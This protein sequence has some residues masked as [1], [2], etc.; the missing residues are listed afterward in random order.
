M[1]ETR[2]QAISDV[3][4]ELQKVIKKYQKPEVNCHSNLSNDATTRMQKN[5]ACDGLVLGSLLKS[6]A[7]NELWPIPLPPFEGLRLVDII[8][9]MRSL[10]P[11]AICDSL[12]NVWTGG[13]QPSPSHGVKS[14][15]DTQLNALEG[16]IDGLNLE[17]FC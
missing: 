3:L 13:K 7:V 9:K 15:I 6:A 11:T 14:K 4:N 17:D 2:Q 8:C 1:E 12:H 16:Q 10:E 5:L